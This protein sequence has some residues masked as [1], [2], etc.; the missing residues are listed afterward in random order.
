[1]TPHAPDELYAGGEL[2]NLGR[3]WDG[4]ST[5]T[6]PYRPLADADVVLW[7]TSFFARNPT[8]DAPR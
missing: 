7:P 1:M 2:Q 8:L 6:K 5:F 3:D 4:L